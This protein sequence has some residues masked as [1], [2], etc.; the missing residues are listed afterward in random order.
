[1]K[2]FSAAQIKAW[3]LVTIKN[4]QIPSSSLMERAAEQLFSWFDQNVDKQVPIVVFCGPGNNGGDGLALA[5]MLWQAHYSVRVFSITDKS[6]SMDN[7][8]NQN[9]LP[10]EMEKTEIKSTEDFPELIPQELI[11]DAIF[12]SGLSKPLK[13]NFAE[14]VDYLNE[15]S[16]LIFSIDVP[17]GMYANKPNGINDAIFVADMTFSFEQ[18]KL[19]FFLEGQGDATGNWLIIPISLDQNF[20]ENEETSYHWVSPQF[21]A[22][23]SQERYKFSHKGDYGHA[24]IIGGSYGMLGAATLTTQACLRS[25]IGKVTAH[26]PSCGYGVMQSSVPEAMVT[27]PTLLDAKA[28]PNTVS[29]FPEEV[30]G[31][32]VIAIGPGLGTH[33]KVAKGLLEFLPKIKKPL[34]LDAD[35][36]NII[37]TKKSNISL[38]PVYSILTPHPGEFKRLLGKEWKDEYEKLD[39]LK[40]FCKKYSLIVV[41]KEACTTI[42]TPDGDLYFNSTGNPGMATA[43]MGDAL[44]GIIAAKLAQGYE[45]LEAAIFGVY[46]H[47]QAGDKAVG[48]KGMEALIT[49][50]LID[51]L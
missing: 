3:D 4:E 49:S 18:P 9:N 29:A 45:S 42:A 34:V 23:Y 40:A 25:G 1:M 19:S 22:S 28:D 30:A 44:T 33:K 6:Y 5:R 13:G 15:V 2:L 14:L 26:I 39:L 20:Y 43:G 38:I 24:L 47:G 27:T 48:K 7:L 10:P 16:N 46:L 12:G 41:L 8:V 21:I 36:L 32:D 35:A 31:Y 50:D 11:V 37:A 17:S 51:A